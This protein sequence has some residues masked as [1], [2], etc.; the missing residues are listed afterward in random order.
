[1]PR[2]RYEPDD[3]DG[4]GSDEYDAYRDYDPDDTDTYPEGVYDDDGPP[5]V[6]CPYCREMVAEDSPRCPNCGNS[7]SQEDLPPLAGRGRVWAVL[8]ALA[9]L[10][11]LLGLALG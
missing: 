4:D 7:I 3:E 11:A 9:L 6:P 10:A 2:R 1:M 8:M 5:E